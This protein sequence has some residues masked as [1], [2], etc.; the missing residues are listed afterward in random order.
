M[1]GA[2]SPEVIEAAVVLTALALAAG[3]GVTGFFFGRATK[4]SAATAGAAS[5][6]PGHVGGPNLP[7]SEIGDP[8]QGA[9]IFVSKH[10]SDCH[11]YEGKGGED[12]PPLDFMRGHLSAAEIAGMS[13]R[14]WNHLPG[15]LEHFRHEKIPFPTFENDQMADLIA[16]LHSG[17]GGPPPVG[18]GMQPGMHMEGG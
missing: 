10:C 6:L 4:G 11:S 18:G 17:Q 16:Y 12:A 2:R 7:V 15:M 13:G 9:Q 14:I 5:T 3:A 1:R 8:A